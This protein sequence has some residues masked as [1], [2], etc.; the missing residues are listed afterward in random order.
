TSSGAV[1][2]LANFVLASRL[3]SGVVRYTRAQFHPWT[4]CGMGWRTYFRPPE[5]PLLVKELS[6]LAARRRTYIFRFVYA[7]LLFA[8]GLIV[9][10][11][12]GASRT[13]SMP[14]L[15]KTL[16]DQLFLIQQIAIL[17]LVPSMTASALT[18][19]KER[20]TLP[21]LLLTTIS[22]FEIILQ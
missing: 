15:G 6:E 8:W 20:E 13:D 1:A 17:L 19:E 10:F 7:T 2:L 16:F 22:P 4:R 12:H 9:L 5:L 18:H 11:G 21:L 14:G 3:S